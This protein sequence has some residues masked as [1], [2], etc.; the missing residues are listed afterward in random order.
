M[1]KKTVMVIHIYLK[2]FY[3]KVDNVKGQN[4]PSKNTNFISGEII[5]LFN[6]EK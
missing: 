6:D 3:N 5:K 4:K 2:Y 1:V